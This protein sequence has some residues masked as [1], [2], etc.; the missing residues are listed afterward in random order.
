MEDKE[1]LHICRLALEQT[2]HERGGTCHVERPTLT[3]GADGMRRSGCG[4][5]KRSNGGGEHDFL[6]TLLS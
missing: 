6:A 1:T 3:F 2:N 5:N 4:E